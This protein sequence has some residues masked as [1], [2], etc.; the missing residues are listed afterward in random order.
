MLAGFSELRVGRSG[1]NAGNLLR[2]VIRYGWGWGRGAG[3]AYLLS[4]S[5]AA[6]P[7]TTSLGLRHSAFVEQF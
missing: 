2:R 4:S 6:Q 3:A 5:S 1:G 7:D